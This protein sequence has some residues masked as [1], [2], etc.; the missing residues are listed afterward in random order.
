VV[1]VQLVN[2]LSSVSSIADKTS[3]STHNVSTSLLG[4]E[5]VLNHLIQRSDA[6]KRI[7]HDLLAA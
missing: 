5:N 4:I 7:N 1:S 6:T 2:T 3:A